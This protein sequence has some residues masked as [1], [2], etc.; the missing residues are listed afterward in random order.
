MKATVATSIEIHQYNKNLM[1]LTEIYIVIYSACKSVLHQYSMLGSHITFSEI[2][3]HFRLFRC[4]L[5]V[6][7]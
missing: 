7:F 2:I 4:L 1:K 6:E 3:E 5:L